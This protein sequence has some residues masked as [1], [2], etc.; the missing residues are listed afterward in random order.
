MA[1]VSFLTILNWLWPSESRRRH[2]DLVGWQVGVV[3]TTYAVIIGF[4]LYAVWNDFEAATSN[5]D[6]EASAVVN[7][8]RLAEG[9]PQEQ[10]VNVQAI[11][12]RYADLMVNREWDAM[13]KA[14]KDPLESQALTQSLWKA[15]IRKQPLDAVEATSLNYTIQELTTLTERRRRRQLQSQT[16]LPG[17]LWTVLITGAIITIGS[18][19]LFGT[20][21]F[22]LHLIQVLALSVLV[23]LSLIAVGDIA[24][25]FQGSVHVGS[26]AFIHAQ[27]VLRSQP[28]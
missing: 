11:A 5:V 13:N 14:P 10:R 18:S 24:R 16:G 19:C 7:L 6:A 12:R 25:P 22:P 3:G 2:N 21:S 20:R 1:S 9:L 27:D 23:S 15:V 8:S 26:E 28:Q 17:I 4:M